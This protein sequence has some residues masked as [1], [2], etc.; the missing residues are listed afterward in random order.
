MVNGK[1]QSVGLR[2]DDKVEANDTIDIPAR[3]F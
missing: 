1:L 3:F 2:L